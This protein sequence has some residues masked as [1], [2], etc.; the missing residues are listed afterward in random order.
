MQNFIYFLVK[1]TFNSESNKDLCKETKADNLL[2]ADL[3]L[4]K[5]ERLLQSECKWTQ[6]EGL[7]CRKELTIEKERGGI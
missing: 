5:F 6:M 1:I 4:K 2:P 3:H 7:R